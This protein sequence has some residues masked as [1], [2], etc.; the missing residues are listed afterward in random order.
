MPSS[1]PG[2]LLRTGPDV[3][4]GRRTVLALPDVGHAVV[5]GAP[6]SG[7]TSIVVDLVADRIL[8]RGWDPS[9]VLVLAPTRTA[10]G[11]LRDRLAGR[12]GVATDGPLARSAL[13]LAFEIVA[14]EFADAGG[15]PPRLLTGAEQDADLAALLAGHLADGSGPAWPERLRPEVRATRAFRA[16]LRDLLARATEHEVDPAR[17]RALG[18]G[19][20]RDAW[21]AAADLADEYLDVAAAARPSQLSPSELARVA[22]AALDAGSTPAAVGALRLVV[23]DDLPEQTEGGLALLAA[24]AR[25][26]VAVIATGDPD[27]AAN[28]FR[29][30]EPDALHRLPALLGG[31]VERIVLPVVHRAGPELRAFTAAITSRVGAAGA[32]PQRRAVSARS[33]GTADSAP[34]G[35]S[36]P[37]ISR[38]EAPTPAR[39]AAAVARVL[40]EER[41]R[42]GVPWRDLA[43]VVRSGS[44]VPRIARALAAAEV[45]VR[46]AAAGVPLRD[47]PAARE[48]LRVLAVGTGAEPLDPGSAALLLGGPYGGLDPLELRGL[49]RELRS[50]EAAGGGSRGGAELLADALAG[51]GRLV[52][53]RG[54]AARAA[55]RMAS[56]LHRIR[57]APAGA[58]AEDLLWLAWEGPRVADRWRELAAGEGPA[59]AEAGRDL[60]AVVELFAVARRFGER[61][62]RA[63]P[64]EF[65]AEL[66]DADVA[67]DSLAPGGVE[68]AVLV[69]TPAAVAG[70]EFATVVIA[71][72]EDGVWPDR[73]PRGSLLAAPRLGLAARGRDGV[74]DER[75]LALDGELR[76]FALAVSRARDRVV[77]SCVSD[78]DRQPSPFLALVPGGPGAVPLLPSRSAPLTL[79]GATGRLR[80]ILTD[81]ATPDATRAAA[82]SS[83]AE[84]ARHGVPGADPGDW[85]GLAAPTTTAPLF[86]E[87]PVPVSPS[88]LRRFEESPLDW[89]LE[90]V[91]G[92]RPTTAMGVGTI[93][94]W[95]MESATDPDADALWAAVE[96]RWAE[97][98]FES[99]WLAEQ[100]RRAA[101]VLVDGLADYLRDRA[102]AGVE[103][104][105]AEGRFRFDLDR[106]RVSGAI[107][108]VERAGDGGVAIVDLKTG[109]PVTS[110]DEIA[111]HPQLG[112]YQLAYAEGLLD[113]ALDGDHHAAGARLLFVRSGVGGSRYREAVQPALDDAALEGFRDRIRQAAIGMAAASF[114]GVVELASYGPGDVAE[115]R[116]HRVGQVSGD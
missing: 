105:A 51:P 93:L 22:V 26:G 84:L 108:R 78:D 35:V 87:G 72:L 58:S 82:A 90:T 109:A 88:K 23:A 44:A 110:A 20:G 60:D 13:S 73:R 65:L 7:K 41:L 36:R 115:L 52:T 15:D 64:A 112:I 43:V 100:Q 103:L 6:G 94:H 25:R 77:L 14:A 68:D 21:V 12:V 56:T 97:L 47:R 86:G 39:E 3:D 107:D 55:D 28:G 98:V 42:V 111:R 8:G 113:G 61:R 40:R 31:D 34:Q 29:G 74:L 2:M 37:P 102:A 57:T 101:R 96:S 79:R 45:P 50:E 104:V 38:I 70:L 4:L 80:R 16:E 17:L 76:M 19:T 33:G 95:A 83:L 27:V 32:G 114:E 66:L 106:A 69:G 54:R 62:P 30:G 67:D 9:E 91:A 85:H 46:T 89:F 5:L 24:L 81:Q 99:P 59:A 1:V 116:L 71:G 75:R 63:T 92:T 53:V 18:R 49:R 11:R 10:A 48:L